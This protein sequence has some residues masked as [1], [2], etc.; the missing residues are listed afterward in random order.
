MNKHPATPYS[1]IWQD[2]FDKL[3]NS[4]EWVFATRYCPVKKPGKQVIA[5]YKA[6]QIALLRSVQ[7]PSQMRRAVAN[8]LAETCI[9]DSLCE[10]L[11]S[12]DAWFSH[13][14]GINLWVIRQFKKVCKDWEH[15]SGNPKFPV[16]DPDRPKD[17]RAA[18]RIYL[19]RHGSDALWD[20]A[21]GELRWALT[22]H[23]IFKWSK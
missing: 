7:R 5:T 4:S 14:Q 22:A 11:T 1:R 13:H 20:G 9:T 18:E 12:D 6:Y 17:E 16:P 10:A 15:Y 21:Y 3:V 8:Y 19:D 2:D 23:V